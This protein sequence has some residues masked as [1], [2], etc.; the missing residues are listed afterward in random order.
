MNLNYTNYGTRQKKWHR[1]SECFSEM[2]LRRS[3]HH[4][5]EGFFHKLE[6]FFRESKVSSKEVEGFFRRAPG[7]YTHRFPKCGAASLTDLPGL[8]LRLP[9]LR[10]CLPSC[11]SNRKAE[12]QRKGFRKRSSFLKTRTVWTQKCKHEVHFLIYPRIWRFSF[13]STCTSSMPKEWKQCC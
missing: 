5:S 12:Q 1:Y 7:S 11:V 4:K 8:C 10:L 9:E 13:E 6:D 2:R 3:S